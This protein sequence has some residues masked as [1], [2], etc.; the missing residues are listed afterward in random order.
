M[1]TTTALTLAS[2]VAAALAIAAAS[3]SLAQ[4][5][6]EKCYG[7][8]KAGQNDCQTATSS[9]AGTAK[10]DAQKDAWIYVPAGLCG[11]IVGGSTKA[12]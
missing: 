8:S 7:V 11:K 1:K 10:K 9:C 5:K 12:S 6:K 4:D 2:A 3:P